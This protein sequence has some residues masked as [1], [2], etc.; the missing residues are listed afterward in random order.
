MGTVQG[1]LFRLGGYDIDVDQPIRILTPELLRLPVKWNSRLITIAGRC[2]FKDNEAT[3]IDLSRMLPFEGWIEVYKTLLHE[4]AHAMVH[5]N[6][7]AG[8]GIDWQLACNALGIEAQQYHY[9][10]FLRGRELKPVAVCDLC[11]YTISKRKA[12]ARNTRWYHKNCGG[13]LQRIK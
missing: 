12:L 9:Y 10:K 11:A 3:Y 5:K 7:G 13:E 4:V 2:H 1:M 6:C 8:H